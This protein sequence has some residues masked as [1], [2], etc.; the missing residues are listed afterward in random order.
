MQMREAAPPLWILEINQA[1][2]VSETFSET[3]SVW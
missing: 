2:N 3:L 1:Q